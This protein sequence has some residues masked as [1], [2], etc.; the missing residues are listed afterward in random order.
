MTIEAIARRG[1]DSPHPGPSAAR[2]RTRDR[3]HLVATGLT[4]DNPDTGT[5]LDVSLE[6]MPGTI[7]HVVSSSTTDSAMLLG[8]LVGL[9]PSAGGALTLDGT[10]ITDIPAATARSS[11]VLVLKDPWI[12]AGSVADNISFGDPTV[13][14]ARIEAVASLVGLDEFLRQTPDGL[15]TPLGA[16][17]VAGPSTGTRRLIAL[18]RA[19][20]RNPA[21]LLI[22][23]PF[24]DLSAREETQ[25]LQAVNAAG[26]DRTTIV[27]TQHFDPA[28]FSTDQV[29]LL[30]AGRLARVRPDG[31]R[32]ALPGPPP[33]PDPSTR[34]PTV[35]AA[36]PE[37]PSAPTPPI[38][39]T[40]PGETDPASAP[41]RTGTDLGHGYRV[42]SL[43]RRGDLT[44]SWLALH[45]TSSTLVEVNIARTEAIADEARGGLLMEYERARRLEH[46]GIARPIAAHLL[47]EPRPFV[48][49][50]RAAGP[51]LSQLIDPTGT[52]PP[53]DVATIGASVA[54]TLSFIH[55]VGF[56]HLG[57]APDAVKVTGCGAML[58]DVR[59]TRAVGAP[60]YPTGATARR[61]GAAPEYL[62]GAPTSPS[63]DLYALGC[64]LFQAATSTILA[65]HAEP[66]VSD[67]DAHLAPALADMVA[68][69]LAP[70][71]DRRPTADE[72]LGCLR[73]LGAPIA[74]D[75]PIEPVPLD[76]VPLDSGPINSVPIAS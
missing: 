56:A 7:T 26:R 36:S 69:M 31:R 12:M 47:T 16:G 61:Q 10:T 59:Y 63:M 34:L 30:E 48:V 76:S 18:A 25:M 60:P 46:P 29:L 72:V 66:D 50:E 33:L 11:I 23:D 37:R 57:I 54:R 35:D 3:G 43:L 64:L 1:P 2:A 75:L 19:L 17:D 74:L 22:E 20:L 52:R 21:V 62:A 13:D 49:Y 67:I 51:F 55:R 65:D 53:L 44:E 9:Y 4:Y 68:S 73:P 42:A 28:M 27:T 39:P 41:L 58:T 6:A 14:R 40:P 15:D 70:D 24:R 71:P 32:V 5:L 45:A 8:L 38:R